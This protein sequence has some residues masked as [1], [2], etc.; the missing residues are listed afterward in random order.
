MKHKIIISEKMEKKLI[1]SILTEND[2]YYPSYEKVLLIKDFLDK[3]FSVASIPDVS[4]NGL[5]TMTKVINVLNS[6]K[7]IVSTIDIHNLYYML[8]EKFKNIEKE[9]FNRN[10]L[11]KQVINDWING[12]IT[13]E[14]GLS[15]NSI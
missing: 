1:N 12:N 6:D 3:N 9:S 15:V 4:S 14:G 13:K 5:P 8:Q 10:K 2:V 7:S 11:L